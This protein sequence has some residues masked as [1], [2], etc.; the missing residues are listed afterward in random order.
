MRQGR[1][2]D[3]SGLARPAL[4]A[5]SDACTAVDAIDRRP[6]QRQMRVWRAWLGPVVLI[7][8]SAPNE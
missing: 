2:R 6:G 8:Y 3:E 1:T 4:T 7:A 5:I